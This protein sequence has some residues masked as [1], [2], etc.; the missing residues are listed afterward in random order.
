MLHRV[1]AIQEPV[2]LCRHPPVLPLQSRAAAIAFA[3][4]QVHYTLGSA[5]RSFVV[6]FGQ[7]PP[8][9]VGWG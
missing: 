4:S 9:R 5:G 2:C 1:Y 7:N 3:R 8:L 6:G